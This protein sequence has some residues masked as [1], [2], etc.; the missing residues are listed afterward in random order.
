MTTFYA[1][2]A[3]GN[4]FPVTPTP[5]GPQAGAGAICVTHA[6]DAV[7]EPGGAAISGAAMPS[8]GVGLTG[9]MSAIW[10]KLSGTLAVSASSLP[11]PSGAATSASQPALNGDGGAL[12]HVTNF[13]A[14][15]VV[16]GSGAAGSPPVNSPVSIAG[17][18]GA[19]K[20]HI[21]T[22]ASGNV[23]VNDAQSAPFAGAVAMTVGTTYAAQRSVGVLC[24]APGN[25]VF[26]FPDISTVTLPVFVGW[27][28]FPFA[29]TQ[30]VSAGTTATA[31]YFNFK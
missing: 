21:R 30:I 1:K 7:A 2:D 3:N 16:S 22:D 13:P 18:D 15:Q 4:Q 10:S 24:T 29:C 17:F 8:G 20:Q 28:I 11:L 23:S 5:I 9:W 26:Q 12:A 19:N 6:S 25:A 14:V 31:T 27:Q